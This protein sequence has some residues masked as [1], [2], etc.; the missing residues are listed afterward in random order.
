MTWLQRYRVRHYFGTRS[1]SFRLRHR[2]PSSPSAFSTGWRGR[3]VGVGVNSDTMRAVLGTL[4]GAMFTFIVFVCSSLLLV[5]QF[6]SASAHPCGIIGILF[7][8]PVTKLTLSMF[9]F[10]F[11]FSISALVRIGNRPGAHGQGCRLQSAA[12]LGLFLYLID[13]VGRM[14]RPSGALLVATGAQSKVVDHVYPRRL[15]TSAR[16]REIPP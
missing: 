6:A 10:T 8:D 15:K 5:V 9:V 12:C 11:T 13:R 4:A 1:G 14:L 3:W 16:R 2:P 7:R